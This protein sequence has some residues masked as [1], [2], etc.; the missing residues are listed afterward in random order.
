MSSR[1]EFKIGEIALI[2]E[3]SYLCQGR[4]MNDATLM[5]YVSEAQNCVIL[6]QDRRLTSIVQYYVFLQQDQIQGWV[7]YYDLE[8]LDG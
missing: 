2:R 6:E 7:Y 4:I 8:K 1:F 5:T 3:N